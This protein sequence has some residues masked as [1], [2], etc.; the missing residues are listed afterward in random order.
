MAVLFAVGS[1]LFALGVPPV[2][3]FASLVGTRGDA[4]VF[5]AGSVFFTC[6]AF[7]QIPRG[8]G[9]LVRMDHNAGGAGCSPWMATGSAGG[10]R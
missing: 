5:F 8:P 1:F 3:G 4:I 10:H 7:L 2:P 9:T 6:A